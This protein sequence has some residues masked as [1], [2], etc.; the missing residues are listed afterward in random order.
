MIFNELVSAEEDGLKMNIAYMID[1]SHNLKNKIEEMIQSV[2]NIFK[3]YAKA[4]IVNRKLL[5]KYQEECDI[6]MAENT[7][8]K[9]FDTDVMPLIYKVREEMGVP[10]DPLKTFRE[11]GYMEKVVKERV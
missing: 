6:V 2:E 4:L 10:L 7:L 1:E 11:S 5:R 3:T 8:V 9:A